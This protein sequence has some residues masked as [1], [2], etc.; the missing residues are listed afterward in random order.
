MKIHPDKL[1]HRL[2]CKI[3]FLKRFKFK[4]IMI[5]ILKKILKIYSRMIKYNQVIMK[6]ILNRRIKK[7]IFK[8]KIKVKKK[9]KK[10]KIRH[11]I[12]LILINNNKY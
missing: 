2:H 12:I 9:Y 1:F 8:V 11:L 6:S 7:I 10:N 3:L 5:L 4:K